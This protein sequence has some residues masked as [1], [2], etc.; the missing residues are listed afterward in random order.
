MLKFTDEH[1]FCSIFKKKRGETPGE[2][3]KTAVYCNKT[4]RNI[5]I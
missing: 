3:R 2:Y 1:Y 5:K 4:L